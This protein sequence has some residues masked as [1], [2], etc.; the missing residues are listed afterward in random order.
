MNIRAATTARR[1]LQLVVILIL[2]ACALPGVQAQNSCLGPG[3]APTNVNIVIGANGLPEFDNRIFCAEENPASNPR[4]GNICL[5]VGQKPVLKFHLTGPGS[6]AWQFVELQLSGDN[7]NWP[8]ELP[9]GAY[10]DFEFA[11]DAAL[12]TGKPHVTINGAQ[13]EVRNNNCHEFK[14]WY[15]ILM[16]KPGTTDFFYYLHPIMDNRGSNN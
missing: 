7:Q 14:V 12:Q 8:G 6:N 15:R 4:N 1:L 16:R 10:S 13:M 9:L 5:D 11:S 3:N 2:T